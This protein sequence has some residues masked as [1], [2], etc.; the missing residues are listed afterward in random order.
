VLFDFDG[1]LALVRAGWMPLMLD[2][3]METL[4]PLGAD[5]G[6]LRDEA[7]EYV[8]RFTGGD[9]VHQM[10]AFADH[11]A[12]LGAVPRA[13]EVYKA[14][15][16][17]RMEHRRSERLNAVESGRMPPDQ[18]LVP[19]SRALLEALRA[20]GMRIFLASG[21]EHEDIC[22]E[23]RLLRIER[24]FEGIYGSAP[25]ILTKRELLAH[26]VA[27]GVPGERIL[28]FGDGRT[29]MEDTKAVGGTAIGV[30]TDERE[31]LAVD[32]KKRG[33]LAS[34][35]ADYIIPNYLDEGLLQL[36][37]GGTEHGD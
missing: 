19:G 35:G 25:Q 33:W 29:E 6:K 24:Y 11:V 26:I 23:A 1:T 14:E 12:S 28:T 15:F 9:T 8:A 34:A 18:L 3:M 2:M 31:C 16:L 4:A 20:A 21:S 27:S 5:T 37:T 30:A 17:R 36:V 13:A 32:V 22:R 7:E 10:A